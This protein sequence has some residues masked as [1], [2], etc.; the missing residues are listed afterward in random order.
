ML[1]GANMPAGVLRSGPSLVCNPSLLAPPVPQVITQYSDRDVPHVLEACE[2]MEA[3]L[4]AAVVSNDIRFVQHVLG[5]TVNGT[6]YA[7]IRGRTTG[8][9]RKGAGEGGTPSF[10]DTRLWQAGRAEEGQRVVC[11]PVLA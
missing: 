8:G 4:T 2:R 11:P 1:G 6:T 7:G 5:S 10:K 9:C 3:H